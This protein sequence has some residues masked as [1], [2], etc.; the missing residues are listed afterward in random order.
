[1][2][3][4]QKRLYKHWKFLIPKRQHFTTKHNDWELV[5][6]LPFNYPNLVETVNNVS[7]IVQNQTSGTEG[8]VT[9]TKLTAIRY[10]SGTHTALYYDMNGTDYVQK[11]NNANE[12]K[13]HVELY[14][15]TY[16]SNGM[17]AHPFFLGNYPSS[18]N[19]WDANV[20]TCCTETYLTTNGN[21]VQR[22]VWTSVECYVN[23]TDNIIQTTN[24]KNS[25]VTQSA[26]SFTKAANRLRYIGCFSKQWSGGGTYTGFVRNFQIYVR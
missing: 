15:Q 23:F 6:N 7:P 1:M 4:T 21:W 24:D 13:L 9:Y 22:N 5:F 14:W 8:G 10:N 17:Y 12:W 2:L 19:V 26:N 3:T 18:T 11:M 25:N 20:L 16:A